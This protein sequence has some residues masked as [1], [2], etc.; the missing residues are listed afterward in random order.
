VKGK[1]IRHIGKKNF[2]FL[3]CEDQKERFFHAGD[4][5]D[6]SK[7]FHDMEVNDVVEFDPIRIDRMV[8]GAI[9]TLD[10]AVNVMWVERNGQL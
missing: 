7:L 2:G 8:A 1:I 9:K 4:V 3:A 6:D 5:N 10:R